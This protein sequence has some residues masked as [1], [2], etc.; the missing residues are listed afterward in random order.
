VEVTEEKTNTRQIKAVIAKTSRGR[1]AF[2]MEHIKT[3]TQQIESIC[4]EMCNNYCKYPTI[5]DEEKDGELADS[6]I[7]SNCP[8]SRL[9]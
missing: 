1:S 6:E 7:C 8:L 4:E 9:N 3:I 5:W 2:E